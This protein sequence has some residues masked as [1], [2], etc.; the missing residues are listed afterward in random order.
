MVSTTPPGPPS[1]AWLLAV[2]TMTNPARASAA[3]ARGGAVNLIPADS[4]VCESGAMGL[5]RL[6][7]S[8]SPDTNESI[9]NRN[10]NSVSPFSR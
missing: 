6:P 7:N 10:G 2:E 1:Q 3:A 8:R 5:S 9:T 4:T